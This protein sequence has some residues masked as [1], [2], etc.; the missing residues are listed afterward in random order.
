MGHLKSL[1]RPL[2]QGNC[3]VSHESPNLLEDAIRKKI[4]AE[5]LTLAERI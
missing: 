5:L 4:E 2:H 3:S 1:F